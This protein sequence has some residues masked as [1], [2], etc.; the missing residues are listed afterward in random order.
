MSK[1]SLRL[2]EFYQLD[3]ELNG[4]SNEG[5]VLVKGLLNENLP[6][7]TKYWLTQ[8]A[9]TVAEEK[10]NMDKFKE[11]LINKFGEKQE[12][13]NISIERFVNDRENPAF[14]LFANEWN[15]LLL[16]EKTIQYKPIKI[17]DLETVNSVNNYPMLFKF[18]SA[19]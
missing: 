1:I 15:K 8:I 5:Q 7:V 16:E 12:N 18:V 19:D 13:G 17:E 2:I 14:I 6:L 4:Y 11:E 9:N 10:S 3:I